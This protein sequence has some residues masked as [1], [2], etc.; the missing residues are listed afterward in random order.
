MINRLTK[1]K[2]IDWFVE[3]MNLQSLNIDKFDN[4]VIKS[5]INFFKVKFKKNYYEKF[6]NEFI[7]DYDAKKQM[8]S[9][10]MPELIIEEICKYQ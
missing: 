6:I 7:I 3:K 1:K 8:T 4:D 2:E 5:K 9:N 10:S